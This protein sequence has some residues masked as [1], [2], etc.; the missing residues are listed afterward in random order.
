ME[1]C[2]ECGRIAE[3]DSYYNRTYCTSCKWSVKGHRTTMEPVPR[4]FIEEGVIMEDAIKAFNECIDA[5]R[6]AM[7]E[8]VRKTSEAFRE[9]DEVVLKPSRDIPKPTKVIGRPLQ[10][11]RRV[12]YI[13]KLC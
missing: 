9:T 3:Y 2:P 7:E 1:F 8:L 10:G 11:H 4:E 12:M 6:K 5:F 13:R